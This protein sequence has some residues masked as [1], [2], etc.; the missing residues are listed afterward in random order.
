MHSS[1]AARRIAG[2]GAAGDRGVAALLR[3]GY[4]GVKKPGGVSGLLLSEAGG[5][6]SPLLQRFYFAPRK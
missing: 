3:E 2:I 5:S 4:A 1:G 6:W